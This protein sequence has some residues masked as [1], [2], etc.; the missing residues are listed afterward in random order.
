[1]LTKIQK[2]GNSLALRIPKTFAL[3]ANL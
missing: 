1:M 3:D 2:W